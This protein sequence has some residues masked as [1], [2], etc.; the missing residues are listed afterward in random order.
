GE[1]INR[2]NYNG[3]FAQTPMFLGTSDP[4]LHVPLERL[5]ATV[6]ILE[7][8]NANVKLMVYQNAGHSINREEIDLANEFV[9]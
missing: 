5:E 3:D 8:M 6:A 9:L 7:Q 4:D 2:D 1:E